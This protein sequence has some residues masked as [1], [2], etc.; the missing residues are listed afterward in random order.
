[1]QG[2]KIFAPAVFLLGVLLCLKGGAA[3]AADTSPVPRQKLLR[4]HWSENKD[5]MKNNHQALLKDRMN[6]EY[7]LT[8]LQQNVSIE[9][10][11]TCHIVR[12]ED[13]APLSAGDRRHFCRDCHAKQNVGINCF[14]CHAS[15][16][17]SDPYVM[18][19]EVKNADMI[20]KRLEQWQATQGGK[21]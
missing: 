1:M 20:K 2:L 14:S 6:A 7:P 13:R 4:G 21:K 3:L 11:V 12:G 5:I 15:L 10:C 16:P 19:K 18:G 17:A 8:V 9:Q